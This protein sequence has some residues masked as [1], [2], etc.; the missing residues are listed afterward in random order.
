MTTTFNDFVL[1]GATWKAI[2]I[3]TG[4]GSAGWL[5][6]ALLALRNKTTIEDLIDEIKTGNRCGDS[7]DAGGSD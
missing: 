1:S 6:Q 7:G 5:F 3:I 4:I 2:F